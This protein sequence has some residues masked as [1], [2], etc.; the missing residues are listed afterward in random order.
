MIHY[1]GIRHHG[2][3]SAMRVK[4]QLDEIKPDLVLVEGP[5]EGNGELLA[6]VGQMKA[7]VAMM[8]HQVGTFKTV[9]YPFAEYSPEWQ[10]ILWASKNSKQLSFMDMSVAQ[11]WAYEA[12][13]QAEQAQLQ[14][15]LEQEIVDLQAKGKNEEEID[16]HITKFYEK[17]FTEESGDLEAWLHYAKA[18][19]FDAFLDHHSES[20]KEDTNLAFEEMVTLMRSDTQERDKFREAIMREQIRAMQGK[21]EFKTIAVVCGA[22]HVPAIRLSSDSKAEKT[23]EKADKDLL[24]TLPKP[25]KNVQGYWVPWSNKYLTSASGYGAGIEAPKLYEE[26][27]RGLQ[28]KEEHAATVN[29]LAK[30]AATLRSKGID[31]PPASVIEATNLV[32]HLAKLRNRQNPSLKEFKDAMQTIWTLGDDH[33]IEENYFDLWIGS[34]YGQLPKSY[35]TSGLEEDFK[36]LVAEYVEKPLK[37]KLDNLIDNSRGIELDL[38]EE[39]DVR[40]HAFFSKIE[41]L[42][43]PLSQ[44][45]WVSGRKAGAHHKNWNVSW[46]TQGWVILKQ[47]AYLGATIEQAAGKK[48]AHAIEESGTFGEV[49]QLLNKAI[50][51]QIAQVIPTLVER[52]DAFSVQPIDVKDLLSLISD[53]E[54]M[55][56]YQNADILPLLYAPL[57]GLTAPMKKSLERA[58]VRLPSQCVNLAPDAAMAMMEI[59]ESVNDNLSLLAKKTAEEGQA[60]SS[61]ANYWGEWK[62]TLK[63]IMDNENT[64]TLIQGRLL[65]IFI[66][67]GEFKEL[68]EKYSDELLP[69]IQRSL[70]VGNEVPKTADW[71]TGLFNTSPGR[72]MYIPEFWKALNDWVEELDEERFV[73]LLPL[74]RRGVKGYSSMDR[75]DIKEILFAKPQDKKKVVTHN[76]SLET[77]NAMLPNIDLWL[78]GK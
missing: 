27:W 30:A 56:K 44:S 28:S 7:P 61:W 72:L 20:H 22:W 62:K 70:S 68:N 6:W 59:I 60:T 12:Q 43:I 76:F 10:A 2:P 46:D 33:I 14:Q 13:K 34:L 75:R 42:G 26:V 8:F 1:I 54:L 29:F 23:L 47:M 78:F 66:D 37:L 18:E 57:K 52:I 63:T 3:G 16:A 5:E 45:G 40:K 58:M 9:L 48:M 17:H 65:R 50:E 53:D 71:L 11:T 25:E 77:A 69:H 67:W 39:R 31:I 19:S 24:K 38:R 55:F 36:A 35:P 15:Q 49:V 51:M 74:F 64:A 4:Q 21:K 73:H 32:N 41:F